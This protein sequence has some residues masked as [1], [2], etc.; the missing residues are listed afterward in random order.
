MVKNPP[1]FSVLGDDPMVEEAER[2]DRSFGVLIGTVYSIFIDP[3]RLSVKD[4]LFGN[5]VQCYLTSEFHD[6]ARDAWGKKVEVTGIIY[7]DPD[8]G[9]PIEV[10]QVKA[11]EI[12]EEDESLFSFRRARGAIPWREDQTL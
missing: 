5:R 11:I 2:K 9:R 4:V 1:D 7:R 8:T 10:R 3:L 6:M 12:L